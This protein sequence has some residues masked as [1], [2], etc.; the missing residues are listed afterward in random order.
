M[1][2]WLS[3]PLPGPF[4]YGRRLGGWHRAHRGPVP[5]SVLLADR[6]GR[7]RAGVL[8]GRRRGVGPDGRRQ[9]GVAQMAR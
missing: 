4:R 6:A 1:P 7:H 2:V 8:A 9:L 3:V 5:Q